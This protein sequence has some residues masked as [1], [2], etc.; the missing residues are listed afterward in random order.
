MGGEEP[1]EGGPQATRQRVRRSGEES[2]GH[3]EGREL[4]VPERVRGTELS[5]V[6]GLSVFCV[7]PDVTPRSL[8]NA[9]LT[10]TCQEK[11]FVETE[12]GERSRLSQHSAAKIAQA[13]AG[14]AG[15]VVQT[16]AMGISELT[17][18]SWDSYWT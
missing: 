9:R 10:S 16:R 3:W 13:G 2:L 18:R 7:G 8:G 11:D 14:A 15:E 1:A 17:R 5:K 4:Y 12:K 6:P